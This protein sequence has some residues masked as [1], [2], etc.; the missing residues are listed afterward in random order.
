MFDLDNKPTHEDALKNREIWVEGLLQSIGEDTKREGLVKTPYRVAKMYDEIFGGYNIDPEKLLSTT[1]QEDAGIEEAEE[2]KLNYQQGMVI[3]RDIAF[4]SHCE[5]HMV[6]FFGKV[7]VGY[8]PGKKVVGISKI[9]RVVDAFARRVQIQ[10]RLTKQIADVIEKV[11]EPQGV[12]VICEAEH[13]CMKMRGVKN[14]CAD[15]VTSAV[16]GAFQEL[17]TRMEFLQLIRRDK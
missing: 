12:I 4:Y 3:V 5:H 14:P 15:T 16:R 1:F 8:I 6:P 17:P 10:E 2:G 11:L 7:H 13:L 9:A